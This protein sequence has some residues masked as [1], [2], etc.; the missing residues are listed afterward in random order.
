MNERKS[1]KL[2]AAYDAYI[3]YVNQASIWRIANSRKYIDE[4]ETLIFEKRQWL[5]RLYKKVR[6]FNNYRVIQKLI[7]ESIDNILSHFS[8]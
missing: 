1:K 4:P 3:W 8:I 7:R 5:N 2:Y 6:E